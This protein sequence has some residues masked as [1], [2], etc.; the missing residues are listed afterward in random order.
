MLT[1]YRHIKEPKYS[2]L[3]YERGYLPKWQIHPFIFKGGITIL[4]RLFRFNDGGKSE[5]D[6]SASARQH[7]KI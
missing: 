2:S 6:N 7:L 5:N 1:Y 3:V 4:A